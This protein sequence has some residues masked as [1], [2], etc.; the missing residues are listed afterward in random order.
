MNHEP[1][2][3]I[4][5]T[6]HPLLRPR[7]FTTEFPGVLGE[8]PSPPALLDLLSLEVDTP[9]SRDEP[10]R[11]A[12]RDMLRHW[13]HKPAGRGKPA[14]EYLVRAVDRGELGSINLAVDIC[15]VISLHS[16]HSIALVDLDKAHPPFRIDRGPEGG[17]YVFNPSGQEMSLDGLICL[18]DSEGPCGNPVKDAQR[19]KTDESTTRTLTVIWGVAGFPER[20]DQAYLWYRQLLE[21]HGGTVLEIPVVLLGPEG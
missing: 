3:R 10:H 14:A 5:V 2:F 15:N 21:A 20:L 17:S 1:P 7:A 13:G 18:F 19:V 11:M 16:N 4:P 9:I 6:P 12:V 8:T